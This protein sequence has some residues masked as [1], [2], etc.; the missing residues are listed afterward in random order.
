MNVA[1][2]GCGLIGQKRLHALGTQHRL[3]AAADVVLERAQA[4]TA[5][6]PNAVATTDWRAAASHPQVD[7][8]VVATTNNWLAPVTLFAIEAGKH[9]LVEKPGARTPE[10]LEPVLA[11]VRHR[12]VC[13]WVGFN[14]RF[15]PAMQKAREIFEIGSLGRLMFIRA[16]YGHGGRLGY[17]QEWRAD[18]E[19]GGGGELI[20][21]GIHLIDLARWF[22]GDFEHVC[23]Y[24]R[25]YFWD[26]PVEDNA[27]L[28]LRT[29][30]NQ[31]A[32]LH[33]S[34]TE[35]KNLFS[36]EIYGHYAK[37][38]IEG[39]GGTYG[40]ERLTYHKMSPEMG[41]PETTIWEYPGP[42]PSWRSEF[43]AFADAAEKQQR[44][45]EV[46]ENAQAALRV[47]QKV[48]RSAAS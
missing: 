28:M 41:P 4:L 18:P 43:E 29:A 14:H 42:D 33:A 19:V 31:V 12:R 27:F 23:G 25:T 44:S 45:T 24:V 47:V 5:R 48:Y 11:A 39:L 3:I 21:Q 34:C 8:V 20:D 16:R 17:E 46:L 35:W 38:H 26:M 22:L 32:W 36:F 1:I 40:T 10:E 6:I 9:V 37:L 2:I 7:G 15:H 30:E 13:V